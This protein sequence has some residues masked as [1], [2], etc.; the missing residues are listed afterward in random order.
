M[1]TRQQRRAKARAPL[2]RKR[3]GQAAFLAA[4]TAVLIGGGVSAFVFRLKPPPITRGAIAGEHWHADYRIE[5]CGKKLAPYPTVEGE[6][7]THG[8]GRI[9][10]HPQTPAY[11]LNN[12]NLGKFFD[13][14]ETDI[15][16]EK[17]KSFIRFPNGKSFTDGDTCPGSNKPEKLILEAN[18]KRVGGDPSLYVMHDNDKIVLRFG[19]EATS[20][21]IQNPLVTPAPTARPTAEPTLAPKPT[22]TPGKR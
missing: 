11:S 17:G 3:R 6:I 2:K 12:A 20:G 22:A 15:G 8:D 7:H 21:T 18:G 4:L 5:I 14:V 13:I 10:I 19:P 16:R 9:H 1:P